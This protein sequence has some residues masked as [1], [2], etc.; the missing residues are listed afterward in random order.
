MKKSNISRKDLYKLENIFKGV[1]DHRRLGILC[2]L[3][4][5]PNLSTEDIT[6][7]FN[8]NYHTGARH[9]RRLVRSGLVFTKREG[10]STLH[11]LSPLGEAMLHFAQN[12]K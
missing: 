8:L 10:S 3:K 2:L 4:E 5:R 7:S 1:A 11:F 6:E 12:V 9:V